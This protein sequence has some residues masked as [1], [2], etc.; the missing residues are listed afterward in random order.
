MI[1]YID[2]IQIKLKFK[3]RERKKEAHLALAP[4]LSDGGPLPVVAHVHR[5]H[6][7]WSCL[8]LHISLFFSF[9]RVIRCEVPWMSKPNTAW[10]FEFLQQEDAQHWSKHVSTKNFGK[11]E[12]NKENWAE[13]INKIKIRT[14]FCRLIKVKLIIQTP[15][16][17]LGDS[18]L[19]QR[20]HFLRFGNSFPPNH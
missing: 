17:H 10:F 16:S 4:N 9:F 15:F 2:P 1:L 3:Q 6:L 18:F 12:E 19:V 7:P 14:N 8:L 5:D 11:C 13:T 20:Q